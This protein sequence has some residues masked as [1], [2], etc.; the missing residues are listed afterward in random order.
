[1]LALLAV[2]LVACGDDSSEHAA[3][4]HPLSG[5]VEVEIDGVIHPVDEDHPLE[6]GYTVRTGPTGRAE[7]LWPDGSVTRLDYLT[8]F[9]IVEIGDSP[10]TVRG[11]QTAGNT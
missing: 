4:L 1:M 9:S 7:I 6:V 5:A 2:V 11:R 3:Q 10:S 8:V